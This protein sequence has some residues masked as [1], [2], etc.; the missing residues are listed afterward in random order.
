M[1]AS[2]IAIYMTLLWKAQDIAHLG[3]SA[4]FGLSVA[5]LLWEKRR[6]LNLQSEIFPTVLGA[7]LIALVLWQSAA[8]SPEVLSH[9]RNINLYST[10]FLRLIPLISAL[11]IGLLA[12]GFK[13]LKQYWQELTIIFFLSVPSVVLSLMVDI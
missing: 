6:R 11:G 1:G 4:L 3:M 7:L 2:L 5:S 9:K 10:S 13:G 8:I 12:S